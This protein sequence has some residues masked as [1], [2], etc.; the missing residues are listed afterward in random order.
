MKLDAFATLEA[1]IRQGT[2]AA[3]AAE[4]HLTASAVSMQMKQLEVYF[5]QPLFDRSGPQMRPTPLAQEACNAMSEALRNLEALRDVSQFALKGALKL[6]VFE[7]LLPAL[8]PPILNYTAEKHPHLDIQLISGR[9]VALTAAVKAGELDA[10][11]VAQPEEGGSSR[12]LWHPMA[13]RPLVLVAP[14]TSIETTPA[15]LLARYEWIRYDP[16]TISGGL[17][18]RHIESLGVQSRVRREFDS[19]AAILSMVSAGFGVS[20]IEIS[21]PS[22]LASYPVRVVSLGKEGPAY[23][24][25][26]AVRKA[27]GGKR[28]VAALKDALHYALVQAEHRRQ[29]VMHARSSLA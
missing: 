23:Q 4:M 8:L 24:L 26:L 29:M 22:L 28:T 1:V 18:K 17:A 20:V 14:P 10:A 16:K 2:L 5:G 27:D 11:L 19:A 3:A 9:T 13:R 25:A 7:S 12:L 15:D 6:G 21:E